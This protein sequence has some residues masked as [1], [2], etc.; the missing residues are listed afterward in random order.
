MDLDSN[1]WEKRYQENNTG[2]DLGAASGPIIKY[3][4]SINDK[5]I[6]ILIPGCGN[7]YEAEWAHKQGF[8]SVHVLDFAETA[9]HN[10]KNR[11]KDFP[12]S[13]IHQEDF[14]LHQGSYDL[15][16]EQTFFCA[17]N[18]NLREKYAEK[19]QQ[20]L[21]NNGKLAGVMFGVEFAGGPPFG[22]NKEEY[23]Q[24]FSP[25]FDILHMEDCYNSIKPRSGNELFIEFKKKTI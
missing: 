23:Y 13:H 21:K 6:D 4:E 19:T 17:I 22:G 2:W 16:I 10:F 7:G 24:Y 8:K 12:E 11:Y 25:L 9:I 1:Y 20:L 5:N 15:I 3:L 14:F 18:R